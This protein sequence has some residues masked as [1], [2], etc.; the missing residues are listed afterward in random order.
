M[1]KLWCWGAGVNGRLGRGTTE[2]SPVA[3]P[4]LAAA[5]GPELSDVKKVALGPSHACAL[6]TDGSLLCWGTNTAGELGIGKTDASAALPA[7]V[8]ALLNSVVDIAVAGNISCAVTADGGVWCW[9]TNQYGWL[10]NGLPSGQALVPGHVLES[11][12]GSS[13]GGAERVGVIWGQF[14]AIK[15]DHSLWCWGDP[16]R[17]PKAKVDSAMVPIGDVSSMGLS[18]LIRS[19]GTLWEALRQSAMVKATQLPPCP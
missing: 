3:V 10:G 11:A 13:F 19:D 7:P 5:G 1:G 2:S 6:K 18:C 14:C 9:G 17:V 16:D 15:K 8:S 4:V 12:G